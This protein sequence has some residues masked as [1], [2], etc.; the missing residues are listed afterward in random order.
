[1]TE[2]RAQELT[3][4]ADISWSCASYH[5]RQ[6]GRS[7]LLQ[8]TYGIPV[9]VYSRKGLDLI[10]A[11]SDDDGAS[12]LRNLDPGKRYILASDVAGEK[13]S[14]GKGHLYIAPATLPVMKRR[15]PDPLR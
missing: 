4:Y 1:V 3:D 7:A 5:V 6:L 11:Y 8:L 10:A 15:Q 9:F 14:V 13:I 2:E 12:K